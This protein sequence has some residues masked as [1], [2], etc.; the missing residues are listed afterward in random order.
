MASLD[1]VQGGYM[2]TVKSISAV[3][4]LFLAFLLPLNI[5]A[6]PPAEQ[7]VARYNGA[8]SGN[9]YASAMAVDASGNLYV[10]GSS[11]G[12]GGDSDYVTVKYD[13]SG[14]ELWVA[15][16]NGPGNTSDG[17]VA[18]KVD[19]LGNVYVTGASLSDTYADYATIK[20]DAS[21][22]ELWVATYRSN[23]EGPFDMEIDGSGNVYVTGGHDYDYATI[24]YD[25][26]GNEVWV[27]IYS[28]PGES[29]EI[30]NALSLDA[31]GNVYI[32]GISWAGETS[33][34]YLTIKYDASGNELWVA[35]YNGSESGYDAA[36]A[37]DLDG[38]GNV[39]VTGSSYGSGPY[40]D[41]ATIKYDS[42]GNELWVARYKGPGNAD[43]LS[44]SIDVDEQGNVYITGLSYGSGT[45][46]DSATIKYDTSGKELWVARYNGI[47]N[48]H[49]YPTDLRIDQ[50]GNVY[51]TGSS[52][53]IVTAQDY[54]T[55]KY[56][57]S[58]NELWVVRYNGTGNGQDWPTALELDALGNVYVTGSS[59][60]GI[61]TGYDYATIKYGSTCQDADSDGY[62]DLSC[63]G[64]DCDDS[65]PSIHPGATENCDVL[66]NDCNPS[67]EDGAGELWL[68]TACDGPDADLCAEGVYEC[69]AGAQICNDTTGDNP[70][71]C[72]GF[73][74]DCDGQTDEDYTPTATTCGTGACA[75]SGQLQCING[76][77]VN[78]CTPGQPS[79][80]LCDGVD[81]DCDGQ[82]DEDFPTLGNACDGPDADLCQEGNIVCTANGSGVECSD[83]TDDT[84]EICDGQD[85]NCN[86]QIDE[87]FISGT[88]NVPG[89]FSTIQ[90]AIDK[91]CNGATILVHN[92]TYVENINF[93]GKAITVRSE[94]GAAN[95]IIKGNLGSVVTF[96]SYETAASILDGF[97]I[98]HNSGID[99]DGIYLYYS[100][101]TISNCTISGN[102]T[103]STNGAGLHLYHSL[104]TIS[105]CTISGNTVLNN[106]GGGIYLYYSSP[107]ISNSTISG[108]TA[109]DGDGGGIYS[110]ASSITLTNCIISD[111]T[112]TSG[113]IVTIGTGG[114]IYIEGGIAQLTNCVI[115]SNTADSVVHGGGGIYS[116]GSLTLTNCTISGNV[117]TNAT[118]GGIFH[119]G[120]GG[121]NPSYLEVVNSILWGDMAAGSPNEVHQNGYATITFSD[122]NPAY[123]TG[124]IQP[125]LSNNINTD[126]LFV[127]S[128]DYHLTPN[129]PCTDAGT[130]EGAP[131]TDIDGDARPHILG[132]G[133]D[134]GADEVMCGDRDGDG[135]F[136]PALCGGAPPSELDCNDNNATVNPYKLEVCDGLDNDCDGQADEGCI[137]PPAPSKLKAKAT[138]DS[139]ILLE[140]NDNSTNEEGFRI[141]RK[142]GK[143]SSGDP[144]LEIGG[145]MDNATSYPD[146]YGVA[147]KP[148]TTYAYRV[149]A[150]NSG[151][152]SG[153]SDCDWATTKKK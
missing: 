56:D 19:T 83:T 146:G 26:E 4:L 78:T 79:P 131:A 15:R 143:C 30:A 50:L 125:S 25:T 140:W 120:A 94:N 58:G 75:S 114:G 59:W 145:V 34:D 97:A 137:I 64:D 148:D 99:G 17:T 14:N 70:D 1:V 122:I 104:P 66:D 39:Y 92:G 115:S 21:G 63:G 111:N 32:T 54:A 142:E 61:G 127:G 22:N 37:I 138:S 53:G 118:G 141:E 117:A 152:T 43:D 128:G 33:A 93:K 13:A 86:G 36:Y 51:V 10:T 72:D 44:T 136:A 80:E 109:D 24:K 69:Q 101:P 106:D 116:I 47:G 68:G 31:S 60:G 40:R 49:D 124:G 91:A 87:G 96:N 48:S 74:N 139:E 71:I 6:A 100:S 73:D 23:S 38:Q 113:S 3:F 20:Y 45:G 82:T 103:S 90:S 110:I 98:T 112:A 89:D 144:W 7:W 12:S 130:D 2:K 28:G 81:N 76:A 29:S 18:V 11:Y 129:S 88:V 77:E 149:R 121:T 62:T 52:Y 42:S 126:P 57:A 85:N 84:L 123:I 134:I 132:G 55:I 150:Y 95:T 108:N 27:A 135:Y 41:Y 151:G 107:V 9:D 5:F 133:Y 46:Y 67:T 16:Y 153:Y 65:N 105:N 35:R 102:T 147:L 8:G 119:I